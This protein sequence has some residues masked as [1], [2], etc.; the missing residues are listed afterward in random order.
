MD[1]YNQ[2]QLANILFT[3]ELQRRLTTAG[4]SVVAHTAH[5]GVIATDI[6]VGAGRATRVVVRLLAQGPADGA[7]PILYAATADLPGD[8]FTGPRHLMHLRGG[9]QVIKRSKTAQDVA[10]AGDL[11]DLSEKLTGV[12]Y[13]G[14]D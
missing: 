3:T 5:S 4:S 9:A 10:L 14:A 6:Y 1:A 7:L 8:S 2:S 13:P 12:A 11:W